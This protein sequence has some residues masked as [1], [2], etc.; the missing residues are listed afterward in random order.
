MFKKL[1]RGIFT[2]FGAVLGYA[3]FALFA[4]YSKGS[5]ETMD[6]TEA[7]TISMG[8]LFAIIFGI[9]FYEVRNCH[10]KGIHAKY[11]GQ[12]KFN[13]SCPC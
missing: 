10:F 2:I 3:A 13:Y 8:V 7:E 5:V 12:Q 1:F 9:L 11:Y 6:L 4:E